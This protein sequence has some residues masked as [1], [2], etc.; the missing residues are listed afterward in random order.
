MRVAGGLMGNKG[1]GR[2]IGGGFGRRCII[3]GLVAQAQIGGK[4]LVVGWIRVNGS[5]AILQHNI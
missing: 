1:N 5:I 3:T 4:A 2:G